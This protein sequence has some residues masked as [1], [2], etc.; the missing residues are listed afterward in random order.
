MNPQSMNKPIRIIG[1]GLLLAGLSP[2]AH[3]EV[4]ISDF[5]SFTLDYTYEQWSGGTFTSDSTNFRVEAND[6]GGGGK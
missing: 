2:L 6:F 1:L 3:G 5:S 4:V